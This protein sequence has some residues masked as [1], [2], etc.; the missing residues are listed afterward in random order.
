MQVCEIKLD[1]AQVDCRIYEPKPEAA[2][3]EEEEDDGRLPLW[4][5]IIVQIIA[6]F[7]E[8]HVVL[9]LTFPW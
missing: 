2:V 4:A 8:W 7:W 9:I 6:A 5:V 3:Q 1:W